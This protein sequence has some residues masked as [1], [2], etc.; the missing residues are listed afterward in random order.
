LRDTRPSS[1][2]PKTLIISWQQLKAA[3]ACPYQG[4]VRFLS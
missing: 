2:V 1:L 3:M 4:D